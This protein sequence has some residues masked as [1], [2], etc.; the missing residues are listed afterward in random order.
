MYLRVWSLMPGATSQQAQI[1][2]VADFYS[3]YLHEAPIHPR[4]DSLTI[5]YCTQTLVLTIP[6]GHRKRSIPFAIAAHCQPRSVLNS[7]TTPATN[8]EN[9]TQPLKQNPIHLYFNLQ[10]LSALQQIWPI[11]DTCRPVLGVAVME[12]AMTETRAP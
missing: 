2:T 10:L 6:S 4:T 11:K 9:Y 12:R 7:T 3:L 1:K 8:P 5:S